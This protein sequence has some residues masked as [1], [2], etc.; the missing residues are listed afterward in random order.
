[1]AA[2]NEFIIPEKQIN[3]HIKFLSCSACY[4]DKYYVYKARDINDV[5]KYVNL[6]KCKEMR[7]SKKFTAF[8]NFN[9]AE[10]DDIFARQAEFLQSFGLKQYVIYDI[11][12]C[13]IICQVYDE[14]IKMNYIMSNVFIEDNY[15]EF[16]QYFVKCTELYSYIR[17][18][19]TKFSAMCE[20]NVFS[21]YFDKKFI[22]VNHEYYYEIDEI[23]AHSI[24]QLDTYM[25]IK[26]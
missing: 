4:I 18:R 26:K 9:L 6:K 2:V 22:E 17:P 5:T 23:K 20:N 1:M 11:P 19:A 15:V 3:D 16:L 8:K 25:K 14:N 13:C 10:Y 7:I 21:I 24:E 12:L